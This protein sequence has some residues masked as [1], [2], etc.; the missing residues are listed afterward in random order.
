MSWCNKI[1][2]AYLQINEYKDPKPPESAKPSKDGF[3]KWMSRGLS[4][5]Q[6]VTGFVTSEFVSDK[7]PDKP[8][9]PITWETDEETGERKPEVE[10]TIKDAASGAAWGTTDAAWNLLTKTPVNPISTIG[11]PALTAPVFAKFGAQKT[12]KAAEA[13][14]YEF[15]PSPP[16]T[17]FYLDPNFYKLAPTAIAS[18]VGGTKSAQTAYINPKAFSGGVD[19]ARGKMPTTT[20]GRIGSG[21]S[22]LQGAADVYRTAK[23]GAEYQGFEKEAKDIATT[24]ANNLVAPLLTT[25]I[26][27][28][29]AGADAAALGA[30]IAGTSSVALPV[31]TTVAAFQTGRAMGAKAEQNIED[32]QQS[33]KRADVISSRESE[34][35]DPE[36]KRLYQIELEKER[37]RMA[38]LEP[39]FFTTLYDKTFG[40]VARSLTGV[41]DP[42]VKAGTVVYPGNVF[43]RSF[44]IK[45]DLEA[46]ELIKKAKE[47]RE[48]RE[49][50]QK[51]MT[52]LLSR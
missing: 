23:K 32:F 18:A 39:G 4:V 49:Q 22:V 48:R 16:G 26:A 27:S 46:S 21:V 14:G 37:E 35:K 15:T 33:A 24:A 45:P 1:S 31:A 44:D 7:L 52:G 17:P 29:L 2:K 3:N 51:E 34:T 11:I 30:S 28:G 8:G 38:D 13:L 20:P 6:A 19:A 47:E 36:K 50:N 25:A 41:S 42:N 10:Y 12:R 43:P 40:N 9:V 5:P